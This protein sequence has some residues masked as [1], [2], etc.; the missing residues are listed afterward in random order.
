[1]AATSASPA[2]VTAFDHADWLQTGYMALPADYDAWEPISLPHSWY[3]TPPVVGNYSWYRMRFELGHVPSRGQSLYFPKVVVTDLTVYVNRTPIWNLSETY[4]RGVAL[5]AVR[6]PI[7]LGLLRA[8][9]NTVH[10]EVNANPDWFHGL[11][12]MYAGDTSTLSEMSAMRSLIQVQS[13]YVIAAAFGTIGLL[14]LLLWFRAG[15]D[16]VLFWYGVS[17]VTLLVATGLWYVSMWHAEFIGW[18]VGLVFMRFHGYLVPFFVLHLR[19]AGRRHLWLEG[20]LWLL[21]ALAFLSVAQPNHLG[22]PAWVAWG[23]SFSALPA[24]LTIPLLLSPRLRT[25]PA[26]IVLLVADFAAAILPFH[27]WATRFGLL[28]FD[29]PYLIYFSPAFVMLAAAVPI[30]DRMLAGARATERY[31]Q[32]L[33]LRVAEKTRELEIGYEKL[34]QVQRDQ[35]LA[36]E[37][38]RIMADMHDGLGA[39]LVALLSVAQSGKARHGEISEGIAGALDELRLT[40]DSVQPV[41]GDVGVVL[42]NVRHRMRSVFERAGIQLVWNVSALPRMDDLTPERIL[43]IQRIFLEVFSNAIRHA[44]ARTVSVFAMRVP[45][46]VR[47]VIEDDGRGFDPGGSHGGTG[48]TNLQLR[49]QQA[50]GMLA[51][52]SRAGEGTRVSL[53]LPLP[54]DARPDPPTAGEAPEPYPDSGISPR[55]AQA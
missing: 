43:A 12:R 35:A 27:D 1:M 8:G 6:I 46:A 31:K 48:L 14:S 9:E 28:D 54:E 21:L 29:R 44:Q 5:T 42:G 53:T 52:E 25:R 36:E 47:I 34:R 51:V 24:L 18:R 20:A 15:R 11:S 2:A 22:P 39:R 4:A 10:L 17:G 37:R 19:L 49:A 40:V 13:I 16:P 23:M 55:P 7:P 32:E 50:G 41:E 38:R 45:G 30:L 33:E 26:V 3:R